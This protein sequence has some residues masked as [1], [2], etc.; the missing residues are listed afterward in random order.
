M[1]KKLIKER[2]IALLKSSFTNAGFWVGTWSITNTATVVTISHQHTS[3]NRY[4]NIYLAP[5]EKK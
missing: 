1:I 4:K 2:I 5:H 3:F